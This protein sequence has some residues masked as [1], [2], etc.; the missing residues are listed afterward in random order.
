MRQHGKLHESLERL[1]ACAD[2]SC[3]DEVK[4]ECARRIDDVNAAMPT[5]ILAAKDGAATISPT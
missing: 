1:A 4:A 3:P 5:L 2:A